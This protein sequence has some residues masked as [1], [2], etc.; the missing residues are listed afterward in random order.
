MKVMKPFFFNHPK[1]FDSVS[2][3]GAHPQLGSQTFATQSLRGKR[4]KL[5]QTLLQAF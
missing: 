3:K 2:S 4:G 5:W 1:A